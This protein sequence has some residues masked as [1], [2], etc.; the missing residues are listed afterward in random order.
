[1]LRFVDE[2]AAAYAVQPGWMS[3]RRLACLSGWRPGPRGWDSRE[4]HPAD[5]P[6]HG[7]P[8][9]AGADRVIVGPIG[10]IGPI[11]I[12]FRGGR[13]RTSSVPSTLLMDDVFEHRVP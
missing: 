8:V 6:V 3:T 11:R 5:A 7:V 10:P 4:P 2:A 13:E 9:Q 1:M 12:S